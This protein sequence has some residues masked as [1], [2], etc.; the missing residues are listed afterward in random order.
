MHKKSLEKRAHRRSTKVSKPVKKYV[1][2]EI[3]K[4]AAP[5]QMAR[6][7]SFTNSYTPGAT[8]T[9]NFALLINPGN[10]TISNQ[11]SQSQITNPTGALYYCNVL[12]HQ[13]DWIKMKKVD[14]RMNFYISLTQSSMVVRMLLVYYKL[15][16]G[17]APNLANILDSSGTITSLYDYNQTDFDDRYSILLDKTHT[18][19]NNS[20][21][22]YS[23]NSLAAGATQA[24]GNSIHIHK[25]LRGLKTNYELSN[26]GTYADIDKG[27]LVLHV[28]TDSS[29]NLSIYTNVKLEYSDWQ[30]PDKK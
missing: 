20:V 9:N 30:K 23:S 13:F 10:N 18:Y 28:I 21:P 26:N 2:R 14:I 22:V 25:N 5:V 1:V 17:A 19:V 15:S 24:K 3:R 16:R 7:M 11:N 27:M 6:S 29:N 4:L 8:A 12:G